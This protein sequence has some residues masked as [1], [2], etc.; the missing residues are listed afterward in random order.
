MRD[1]EVRLTQGAK[2]Y[3]ARGN[4]E[5]DL[6]ARARTE[7]AEIMESKEDEQAWEWPMQEWFFFH[8]FDVGDQHFM[9]FCEPDHIVCDTAVMREYEALTAGPFAGKKLMMPEPETYEGAALFSG[10]EFDDGD[11]V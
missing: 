1:F 11:D 10:E 2:V 7:V 3:V 5:A 4:S 8:S 6:L 9:L